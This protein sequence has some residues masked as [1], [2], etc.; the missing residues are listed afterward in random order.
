MTTIFGIRLLSRQV[1]SLKFQETLSKYGCNIKTRIGLH[2]I[3]DGVCSPD[4]VILLEVVGDER[5]LSG[6]MA[7]LRQIEGL[8]L[9]TM[10]L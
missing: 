10:L 8:K 4:G 6:M 3:S 7:D 5:I 1:A 9:E 2:D